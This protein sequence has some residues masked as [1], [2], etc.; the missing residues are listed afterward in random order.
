[1]QTIENK[2]LLLAQEF[3]SFTNRN[4]FLT[5]KAGTGKTTFLRNLKTFCPKRMIVVAPTGVAAINAGGVTIHSFF[6]LP[7]SPFIQGFSQASN[8]KN[9][10]DSQA[11]YSFKL[12]RNKIKIIRSLDLLVIDEI[13]MVRADLL[14][15]VNEVL[16]KYRR[17]NKPFGG[18]QLLM[19]GDLHQLAPVVKEDE[20]LMLKDYYNSAFFF[21]SIALQKT[22]FVSIELKHIY[23]QSDKIFIN[24]LGEIRNNKL[25]QDSIELLNSRYIPNFRPDENHGYITLT[26]HNATAQLINDNKLA[27]IKLKS[28]IFNANVKNDFPE[29]LYPTEKELELKVGAQVMFIKNDSSLEKRYYNGK[30]AI[31]TEFGKD[32][33]IVEADDEEIFVKTE[34]WENVKYSLN[35][36]TKEIDEEVI[37]SFEQFPLKLAWAITVHK[38]QGLTFE[39]AVIDVNAAFAFGQV[40]VA[41]SR[42]KSLEGLVLISKIPPSAIKTDSTI[43]EFNKNAEENAP[44]AEKLN[45]SKLIYQQNLIYEQFDFQTIKKNYFFIRK[46]YNENISKFGDGFVNMFEEISK[47][48]QAEIFEVND[49]FNLQL[50]YLFQSKILPEESD[51]IIDRISKASK[52][53]IEKINDIFVS[54][55]TSSY[56]DCDNKEINNEIDKAIEKFELELKIKLASMEVSSVKF[57][58]VKYL[59]T[60]ANTEIDFKSK[61]NRKTVYIKHEDF[62]HGALYAELNAWRKSLADDAG[63]DVYKVLPYKTLSELVEKMPQNIYQ[64]SKIQGIGKVKIKQFGEEI[65]DIIDDYC[66]KN[67]I[68]RETFPEEENPNFKRSTKKRQKEKLLKEPQKDTKTISFELFKQGKSIFE[69]SQERGFVE[70]TIMG[71]LSYFVLRGELEI[72]KIIETERL[73]KIRNFIAKQENRNL[74]DLVQNSNFEFNYNE[75]RLVISVEENKTVN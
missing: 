34:K 6:Q 26:T 33:I 44:D 59:R 7:F 15:A 37:G 75:L 56:F 51:L 27:D 13:S 53:F 61:F 1:M 11:S 31:I 24:L 54:K 68:V 16:K 4:I 10:S 3:V 38:S 19:I 32:F 62:Q 58:T 72:E 20:W 14:D 73:E 57:D 55:F 39:K 22:D 60:V 36:S 9:E 5:G 67:N 74:R 70:S 69:I 29:Y 30:I 65:L 50:N 63:I 8:S 12:S 25:T 45:S 42:C 21:S 46:V 35:E 41:L 66:K 17:S 2:E 47:R 48:S 23:R 71:H 28:K 18:V 52:Y 49:K 43:S 40:Y 64:L